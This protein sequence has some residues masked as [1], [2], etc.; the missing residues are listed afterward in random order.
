MKTVV[1]IYTGQGLADP[2]KQLFQQVLPDC[3][4]VNIIDDGLIH[5][6]NREGE[7]SKAI[8]RRLIG[9]YRQA[10]DM[11]ADVILNTCSS[12]G[13]IVDLA[14]PLID[15]PIVKIDEAMANEAVRSFGRIGVIATLP[16]TLQP[17]VRLLKAQAAKLGREVA[18]ADGLADGAFHALINGR[19]E[20]HDR[21]ITETAQLLAASCDG[22]VLAQGSMARMEQRL[23]ELT[24]KPVLSSPRL[25]L[26]AVKAMLEQN[27]YSA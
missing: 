21:L 9:Y 27:T 15:V 19:P 3:R 11:G 22:L 7:V 26:M 8:V 10:A 16:S 4:L 20:E 2:L 13:E 12:V 25:G 1:A 17:T 24:G 5:D 18:V 23:G 6:V 14:L